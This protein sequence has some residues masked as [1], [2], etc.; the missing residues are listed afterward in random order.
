MLAHYFSRSFLFLPVLL[1]GLAVI[2]AL[3]FILQLKRRRQTT[4]THSQQQTTVGEHTD[5]LSDYGTS[6]YAAIVDEAR[7]KMDDFTG[8]FESLYK[9]SIRGSSDSCRL[10]LEEIGS[11][12]RHFNGCDHMKAWMAKQMSN[13]HLWDDHT[14]RRKTA[15]VLQLFEDAGLEKDDRLQVT[16]DSDTANRYYH[17]EIDKMPLGETYRVTSPCWTMKGHVLEKGILE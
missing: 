4:Q 3:L 15:L 12:T 13:N 6:T 14:A 1:F 16:V 8:C 9:A 5:N 17:D 10:I 11:R 7:R 2:V